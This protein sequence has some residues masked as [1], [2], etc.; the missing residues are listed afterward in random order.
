MIQ[1]HVDMS[2]DPAKEAQ[3]LRDFETHFKPAAAQYA[4]YI[5]VKIVK[6]RKAFIGRAPEGINYRFVLRY[7][8]EELRQKWITSDIHQEVWGMIEQTFL[9]TNYDVLLFDE[10]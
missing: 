1:I 10:V 2:V 5:D 4:G 3:M 7:E 6:L 8:S 9:H